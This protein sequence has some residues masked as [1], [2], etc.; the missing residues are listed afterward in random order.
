LSWVDQKESKASLSFSLCM[1]QRR[2]HSW[3]VAS[4]NEKVGS[5]SCSRLCAGDMGVIYH[6]FASS[7]EGMR[8][9]VVVMPYNSTDY[10]ESAR[11]H[12]PQPTTTPSIDQNFTT[13]WTCFGKPSREE[14]EQERYSCCHG[15]QLLSHNGREN[16]SMRQRKEEK[17]SE[18]SGI[19]EEMMS[20]AAFHGFYSN[21]V[22]ST[23]EKKRA[24]RRSNAS[25]R[26]WRQGFHGR[27]WRN[28]C[29]KSCCCGC[30][31]G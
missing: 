11:Y 19:G 30:S 29:R 21:I 12:S 18:I 28:N 23:I 17:W 24:S 26:N 13:T 9:K 8:T 5:D 15:E 22:H 2:V 3:L 6:R 4:S 20:S 31:S 1:L 14:A 27:Y 7:P 25:V 16:N 10:Y